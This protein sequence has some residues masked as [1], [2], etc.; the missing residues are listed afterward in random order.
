M[1]ER[2]ESEPEMNC[3]Y[4]DMC[5]V[6]LG[7]LVIDGSAHVVLRAFR[8]SILSTFNNPTRF[9]MA[10]P[11]N[12]KKPSKATGGLPGASSASNT[13]ASAPKNDAGTPT[14]NEGPAGSDVARS[15]VHKAG[16]SA[17]STET[18]SKVNVAGA[19]SKQVSRSIQPQRMCT[20]LAGH[21]SEHCGNRG[22]GYCPSEGW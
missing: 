11:K 8:L 3:P 13:R 10:R 7:R 17:A 5:S 4:L 14:A 6:W 20:H 18:R 16:T 15:K 12:S 22:Q 1:G 21:L 19:S 2:S 9:K